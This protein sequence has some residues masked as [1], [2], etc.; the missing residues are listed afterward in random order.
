LGDVLTA[1]DACEQVPEGEAGA[2]RWRLAGTSVLPWSGRLEDLVEAARGVRNV[3]IP[4]W[5]STTRRPPPAD[6][7]SLVAVARAVLTAAAGSV[8]V[9]QLVAVFVARFPVVLDP[10]VGPL[11]MSWQVTSLVKGS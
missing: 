4:K 5:S 2:G 6:R 9:G 3:K 11:P 10:A 8:E 7:A 1:E